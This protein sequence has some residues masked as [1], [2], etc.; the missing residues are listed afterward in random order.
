MTDGMAPLKVAFAGAAAGHGWARDA[1]LGA[2]NA[3]AGVA[4]QAVSARTQPNADAAA[5]AFGAP[6]AFGDTL[7]MVRSPDVDLVAVT[8]KVPEHRAIVLAALAAGKHVYCEWPLG[9]DSAEAEEMATAALAATGHAVIGLQGAD[10]PTIRAAAALVASGAIGRPLSLNVVSAT[11]GWGSVVLPGYAYL[12]DPA[13]G[14]TM[15]RIA[16]G[17][18]LA[19]VEAVVGAYAEVSAR[20]TTLSPHVMIRGTGEFIDS[21]EQIVRNIADHMVVTGCHAGGCVSSVEIVGGAPDIPF[22]FELRGTDGMIE[23]TGG[24]PGGYQA[25]VQ[26]L[27]A[28]VAFTPLPAAPWDALTGPPHNVAALYA[29]MLDDIAS[30][31][32]DAPGFDRAVALTRLLETIDRAAADGRTIAVG[33]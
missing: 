32:H 15:A 28:T 14:A 2:V 4:L 22:R 19:A 3:V 31:T 30:G 17:H 25:G 16:G 6:Q 7:A 9:R 23:I 33:D 29:R 21:G 8:V 1:H 26:A 24:H 12:E 18:T 11:G 27:Q 20:C 5:H 13:N 10:A